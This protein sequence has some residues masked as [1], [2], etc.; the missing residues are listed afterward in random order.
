MYLREY[1]NVLRETEEKSHALL[2]KASK[3]EANAL[4][5]KYLILLREDAGESTQKRIELI[6]SYLLEYGVKVLD[7][8]E[9]T[10]V[11][12]EEKIDIFMREFT[13]GYGSLYNS[14]QRV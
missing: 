5:S 8:S 4:L 1:F 13:L 7:V 11:D 12:T 6:N 10:A 3:L 2:T 14:L 9:H